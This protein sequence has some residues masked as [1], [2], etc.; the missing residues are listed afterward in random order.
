VTFLAAVI[1]I[2][3][4]TVVGALAGGS[5]DEGTRTITRV[6]TR[7]VAQPQVASPKTATDPGGIAITPPAAADTPDTLKELYDSGRVENPT[8]A[9]FG[10][11]TI[12]KKTYEGVLM[13]TD[14]K[15]LVAGYV[16]RL[17]IN[18]K[19]RY[20]Q[21][22]GVVGIDDEAECTENDA[23]VSITNDDGRT[24]W[25]PR[26]VKFNS[27]GSFIV[28]IRNRARVTLDQLS[29]ASSDDPCDGVA[30]LAWGDLK[31]VK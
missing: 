23:T 24:L 7:T 18:V 21:V 22:T 15:G 12:A 31:F 19:G 6:V 11:V 3:C 20:K 26:E 25:G 30:Y 28:S 2:V 14:R 17:V 10:I 8:F 5:S 9:D 29:L 4:G 13:H 1:V 27:P 16:P